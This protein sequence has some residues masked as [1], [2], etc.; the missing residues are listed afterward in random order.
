MGTAGEVNAEERVDVGSVVRAVLAAHE[1]P[2]RVQLLGQNHRQRGLHALAELQPVDSYCDL[3]VGRNLHEGRRL[4][5]WLEG[6]GSLA[7]TFVLCRYQ[8]GKCAEGE[9]GGAG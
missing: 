7:G 1:T 4:L 2:V 3:A 6:A 5:R 9:P 8:V